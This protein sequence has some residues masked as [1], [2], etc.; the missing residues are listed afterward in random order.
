MKIAVMG[1][2]G[3]GG[4]FGAR[5][6]AAGHDV[7]FV[8]RGKHLEAI[9]K[10]GLNV[11]S[12]LLGDV[13][14]QPAK[15]TDDPRTIG[16][17]DLVLFC[18]KLWDTDTAADAIKPA[19]GAETAVLSLQNGIRRDEVLRAR[20][21]EEKVL[22]GVSFIAATIKDAGVIEQR[23]TIQKLIFGEYSGASTVRVKAFEEACKQAKIEANV[24]ADIS[25]TIW[26]KFIYLVAMSSV[27]AACRQTIGPVRSNPRTRQ[28]LVD[29]MN[30]TA[31]VA[32]ARGVTVDDGLVDRH[33]GYFD[34]LAPDVTASMQHDLSVGNKLE[35]PWLA[36]AVVE[37][38]QEL[39]VATSVTRVLESILSPYSNGQ[40][41]AG[42]IKR[43]S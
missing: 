4:A 17:V 1:S 19:I 3:V 13:H 33:M 34:G 27:L 35:L 36:G 32:R 6:A 39:S 14:V 23:G 20:L 43:P 18:V 10:N 42:P 21:G 38:G 28:L 22:G 26:E 11:I 15:C 37:L 41:A 9:R 31:A 30:E 24:A 5:L 40:A 16:T 8:A 25:K 2:G 29:V 12:P 7:T